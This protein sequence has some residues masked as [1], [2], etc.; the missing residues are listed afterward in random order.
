MEAII[1][2]G[3]ILILRMFFSNPDKPSWAAHDAKTKIAVAGRQRRVAPTGN[4]END[5][6]IVPTA[7]TTYTLVP[8]EVHRSSAD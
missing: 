7:A 6:L 3:M 1:A 8:E 4:T 5:S 2:I